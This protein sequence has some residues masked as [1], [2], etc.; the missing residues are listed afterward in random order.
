MK[1]IALILL[2]FI[3]CTTAPK[4]NYE[5]DVNDDGK[6]DGQGTLT[7]I[8]GAR[9][10][11]EFKDGNYNGQGTFTYPSGET[12]TG[13]WL[14]NVRH[15]GQGTF[16]HP[17]GTKY[18]GEF[19][20]GK[21]NG[22]GTY[23]FP[24]GRKYIGE[25]KDGKWNGQGTYTFP[26]GRKYIGEFKDGRSS[27]QGTFTFPNGKKYVGEFK[28]GK[29]NG[30]GTLTLPDGT[31]YV[32]QWKNNKKWGL[33]TLSLSAGAKYVGEWIVGLANGK[34]VMYKVNGEIL[35][36]IWENDS[37][38]DVWTIE[39][40]ENFLKNK[41]PQFKGLD[42][43]IPTPSVSLQKKDITELP[44]PPE[45]LTNIAVVD[46]NGNNISDG[47]VRAL[48]DRLRTELFN[49]KYFKVI[50]REMMQEVIK[51]QGFQQTGC[52]TDECMVEI[53]R[54]IGVE[55]I[56]GGS[57]SKVGNIYSVSSR[58]VN[59]ETG[60]I[61]NTAVFDHTGNIGLLLTEGM[62]IIAVDLIK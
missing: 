8:S 29:Q 19:K 49:T 47:E 57:I 60:E 31:E 15:T 45:T 7:H 36:G 53:G 56:I 40:V 17:S 27:G 21:W 18:I 33:G 10:V 11:G 58:I 5:G 2:F 51:E 6:Y 12:W 9:Y 44:P 16:I 35:S 4:I 28:D 23:A 52:T 41:Y 42:Y 50:E 38:K 54:L 46:F 14:N 22:Q 3:S 39:A 59:V 20:D 55:K 62:R 32:G 30:Q 26:D 25:F 24:D 43:E 34:G 13:E 48:T 1:R 37:F 61:E